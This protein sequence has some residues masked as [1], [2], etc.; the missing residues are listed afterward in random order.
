MLLVKCDVYGSMQ[1]L[2]VDLSVFVPDVVP[3]VPFYRVQQIMNGGVGSM[4]S[5][6][7][8][9]EMLFPCSC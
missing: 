5:S 4:V 1:K 2:R 3:S 8:F 9:S 6:I 7:D